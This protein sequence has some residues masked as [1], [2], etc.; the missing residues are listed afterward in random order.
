VRRLTLL[1]AALT[2]GG[3]PRAALTAQEREPSLTTVIDS[4]DVVGQRRTTRAQILALASIPL[5]QEISYRDVQR[6]VEALFGSGQYDDVR[7]TQGVVDGR[8][9]LRLE[10][11]ERPMLLGWSVRGV[12]KLTLRSVRGKVKLDEGR[13]YS[14]SAAQRALAAIDSLY[15]KEGYYRS[16][17]EVRVLP[18]EEGTVRVVFDVDEGR[19]VAI[20][21]I[22]IEG[23][24]E[25]TDGQVAGHMKT[26]TEG[27]WWFQR[28]EYDETELER[29]VRERLPGFYASRGFID[30]R[31]LRDTLIVREETGKGILQLEVS[32]GEQYAVGT[33]EILGNR[34]FSTEQLQQYYPFTGSRSTGFLGLGGTISAG[35]FDEARWSSATQEVQTLYGNNGYLY[36]E[37]RPIVSR[38]TEADGSRKVDLRW[39]ILEGEP[40]TIRKVV[41]LGNTITHE[42]VVR[43]A[44][45]PLV[46]GDV[47]RQDALIGAYQ[48]VSNLGFFQQPVEVPQIQPTD[49]RV[50]VDV[51]FRVEERRTGNINF[52]ASVGQGTGLGGFIGLD[53]PNVMGRGK[54]LQFQWQ[55]GR[56]IQDLNVTYSDPA[57]RGSLISGSLSLHN[58]RLRYTIADLGRIRTRGGSFQLGF[59]FF[60]SRYTRVV[61]SYTLEESD[62][63]S[64]TLSSRYRCTNCLLS[65]VGLGLVRD[66][67]IDMPFAT[68]GSFYE[69]RF[70][71]NGGFLGGDGSFRRLTGEG[72]WYA[73]LF[74]LGGSGPGGGGVRF[75]LGFRTEVGFVWG[76]AGPHFRQLFALGGTQYGIPLRGYDEFSVTPAGFDP[77]ASGTSASTVDAFGSS[78]LVSTTEFGMRVSQALYLSLFYDAGNVWATPGQFSPTRLF[79]GA[80]IGVAVLS[81][82]GPIGLDY[83]YGFDRVDLL[84]NPAPGWKLHFRLGNIF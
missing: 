39:Q 50:D 64:P 28:G 75:V 74:Q 66:R 26:G 24:T 35:V 44:T 83:A 67:R 81:P 18:Q 1:A 6:A 68:A 20:S 16:T 80:G 73:P 38:R 42:S 29:D 2:L 37:V 57:I 40:A 60:G 53:E 19:R 65:A 78:Y 30:F 14:P 82:L 77:R 36:A 10:V 48:N 21:Q 61:T 4:I 33:F 3:A 70:S 31:V 47:F 12:E 41:I 71:L 27:F 22:Q 56:N 79:R 58:T 45:F 34:R 9:I 54:R 43:R 13:P 32:E 11:I 15:R 46:P 84:G 69:T 5:G 76:D 59:P 23:N 55:F 51:V 49:N 63:D 62:Y 17:A 25:F 52:G 72:R 7:A 8:Q